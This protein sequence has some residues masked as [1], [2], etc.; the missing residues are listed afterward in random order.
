MHVYICVGGMCGICV[1]C[2]WDMCG[3]CVEMCLGMGVGMFVR[4]CG[5]VCGDGWGC[6]GVLSGCIALNEHVDNWHHLVVI[7]KSV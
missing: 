3:V 1:G 5:D 2:V 4:M 6:A 7:N